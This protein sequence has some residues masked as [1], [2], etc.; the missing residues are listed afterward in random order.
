MM[1]QE[2]QVVS[3]DVLR[4][5]A[6]SGCTAYD[7]EFVALAQELGVAFAVEE[8]EAADPVHVSGLGANS[9]CGGWRHEPGRGV[10]KVSGS[11]VHPPGI[12]FGKHKV[13]T[14]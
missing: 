1:G 9:V 6:R 13:Y 2:Y 4:L 7:C 14:M 12:D 3:S 10:F 5:A 11:L 8:D